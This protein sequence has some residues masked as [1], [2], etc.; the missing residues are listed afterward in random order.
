[1]RDHP[2]FGMECSH[3][4][5]SSCTQKI[6]VGSWKAISMTLKAIPKVFE[7]VPVEVR[8]ITKVYYGVILQGKEI[9]VVGLVVKDKNDG[10]KHLQ[11]GT[12]AVPPKINKKEAISQV[13]KIEKLQC[14]V[15]VPK[16][17]AVIRVKLFVKYPNTV[18][19]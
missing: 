15:Y 12:L 19:I 9:I 6:T 10:S 14:N 3:R 17:A 13:L 2:W 8:E 11:L 16:G 7:N 18:D 5:H 1:M 4:N